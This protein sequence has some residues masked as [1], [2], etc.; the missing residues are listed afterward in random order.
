MICLVRLDQAKNGP[1]SCG[2]I[3]LSVCLSVFFVNLLLNKVHALC[4]LG[5][6]FLK[7]GEESWRVLV[8]FYA[9]KNEHR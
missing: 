6:A 1:V 7:E 8:V 5:G 9:A 4:A 3:F 2:R